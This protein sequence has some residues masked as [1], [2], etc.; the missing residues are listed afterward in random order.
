MTPQALVAIAA[1]V[2]LSF[3][4]LHGSGRIVHN[5]L[6]AVKV[7]ALVMFIALGLSI[8]ARVVRAICDQRHTVASAG[9]RAGCSRSFR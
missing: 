4:H 6:A 1:I 7:L 5:L 8:G 3:V 2:A 9:H